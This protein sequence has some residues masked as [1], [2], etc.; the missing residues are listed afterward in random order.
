MNNMTAEWRGIRMKIRK[1]L[2]PV[3]FAEPVH[4]EVIVQITIP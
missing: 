1:K 2:L 4:K 3:E